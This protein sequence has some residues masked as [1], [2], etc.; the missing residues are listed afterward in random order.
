MIYVDCILLPKCSII[1]G[2]YN[3]IYNIYEYIY[4]Y[5]M[6]INKLIAFM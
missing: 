5:I 1:Y 4:F 3:I 2:I 6:H